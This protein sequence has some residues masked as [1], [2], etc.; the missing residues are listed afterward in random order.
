MEELIPVQL[1]MPPIVAWS[2]HKEREYQPDE[3]RLDKLPG[4]V[5]IVIQAKDAIQV[6]QK[7]GENN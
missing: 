5:P 4:D 6:W 2:K 7:H 3:I 1:S